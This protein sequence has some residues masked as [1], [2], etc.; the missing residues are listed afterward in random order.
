MAVNRKLGFYNVANAYL[1]TE[2]IQN[3]FNMKKIK[4]AY[5]ASHF[6][7]DILATH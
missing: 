3:Y 1:L 4:V 2:Y 5:F 6:F 7:A